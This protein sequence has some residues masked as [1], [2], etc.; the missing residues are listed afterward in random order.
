M[1]QAMALDNAIAA[2][3]GMIACS[4]AA[5]IV[6]GAGFRTINMEK[7]VQLASVA[8]WACHSG[9]VISG[10]SMCLVC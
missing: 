7:M 2:H 6:A 10:I 4:C 5:C 1:Q 8:P 9:L 3:T